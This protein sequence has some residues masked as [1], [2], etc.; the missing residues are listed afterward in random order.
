MSGLDGVELNVN[1]T[2]FKGVWI[3]IVLSMATSIGGGI[4]AASQFFARIDGIEERLNAIQV[5]DLTDI[6]DRVGLVE[7]RLVDQNIAGLQGKLAEL[8]ANLEQIMERQR[9]LLDLRDRVETAER[10]AGESAITVESQADIVSKYD[11]RM[12]S[13]RREIDDLWNAMDAVS[14]P[15]Q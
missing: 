5:P 2:S 14:N 6:T 3:A 7:Q 8:G 13:L 4:W 1:G 11:D 15:L 10:Q 12:Q 9:E